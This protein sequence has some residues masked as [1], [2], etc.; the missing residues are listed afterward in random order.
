MAN[1]LIDIEGIA[2]NYA[3]TLAD[4]GLTNTDDLLDA[5]GT[6]FGRKRLSAKTGLS[7]SQLLEWVNRADLMRV[8]GVGSEY[9]DLLEA[10]G[11]DTVKELA[12]RAPANLAAKMAEVNEAKK[13]VRRVPS[14]AEVSAWVAEAKNLPAKVSPRSH[15]Q[16]EDRARRLEAFYRAAGSWS[17]IDTDKLVEDIYDR[18]RGASRPS[19]DL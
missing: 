1:R 16:S 19:A 11:V 13:L 9:S 2:A 7:E 15:P 12:T 3:K 14:E 17:D 10:S 5:A 4:A 18:R 8:K 6:A